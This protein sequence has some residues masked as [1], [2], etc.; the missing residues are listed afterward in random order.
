M[1]GEQF[2]GSG[3]LTNYFGVS[4]IMAGLCET[5]GDLASFVSLTGVTL[6]GQSS[7]C[8]V[9]IS[10]FWQK[11]GWHAGTRGGPPGASSLLFV[12]SVLGVCR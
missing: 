1:G 6:T 9:A 11:P 3:L 5:Y 2:D 4:V 7:E 12:W 10:L 8:P